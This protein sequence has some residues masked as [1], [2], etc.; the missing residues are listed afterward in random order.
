MSI[1]CRHRIA[2]LALSLLATGTLAAL[3]ARA[4]DVPTPR[5]GVSLGGRAAYFWPVGAGADNGDWM[6]GAQL[7]VYLAKFFAVEGSADYRQQHYNGS[8]TTAD[9]YPVQASA[10]LY[11]LPNSRLSPFLLGGVGWYF[12]HTQGPDGFSDTQN[13]FG[14]HIGGGLQMFLSRHWSIDATYRYIFTDRIKTFSNGA[15]ESISGDGHMVT[16]GLNF[17]F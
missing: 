17:H 3:P 13:R 4:D 6:G 5:P 9:I 15:N 12:T 11:L 10:L 14:S 2:A 8:S 16:G 1:K 7:R